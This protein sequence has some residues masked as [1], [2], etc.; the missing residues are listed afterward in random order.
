MKFLVYRCVKEPDYFIVTD[1]DHVHKV[2]GS[3]C[4]SGGDVEEIGE[5]DEMGKSR[6]AFDETL[7]KNSIEHQGYYL[8]E[9]STFAPVSKSRG[10]MPG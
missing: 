7:A 4:P 5:Y 6:V 1:K 10:T 9:A 2:K 3:L 8:F